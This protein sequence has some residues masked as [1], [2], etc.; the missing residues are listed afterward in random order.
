MYYLCM[1]SYIIQIFSDRARIA[2]LCLTAVCAATAWS[3]P[4]KNVARVYLVEQGPVPGQSGGFW[5]NREPVVA[6]L[7]PWGGSAEDANGR[8]YLA[9]DGANLYVRAEVSD[10]SPQ[11][12][13]ADAAPGTVWNGTSVEVFFG[14]KRSKHQDYEEGDSQLQLWVSGT[15]E[16]VPQARAARNGRIL[17]ERQYRAALVEWGDK[18][19]II[20]ASFSLDMLGIYKP[21]KANQRVRCEFRINHAKPGADRSVIVNWQTSTDSSSNNPSVWSDGIIAGD[22]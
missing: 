3:A 22:K 12:H 13:A 5:E 1:S 18:S 21:L 14:V 2:A 6:G 7:H 19:Y 10:A 20:E 11:L 9:A 4:A 16:G 17:N 8:F 15:D